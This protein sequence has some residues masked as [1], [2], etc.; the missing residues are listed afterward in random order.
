MSD[1][2]NSS[3]DQATDLVNCTILLNG[4]AI[5]GEYKVISLHGQKAFNRIADAKIVLSDG[6]PALQDFP[7]SSKDD[8]CKPGGKLEI[9]MGYHSQ[10]KTLFKGIIVSHSIR[11]AKNKQSFL[12][13]EARDQAYRLCLGRNNHC[14]ADQSDSDILEAV[15]K[16]AGYAGGDLDITAIAFKHRQMVQYN[17]SGWDFIVSRAEMNGMLVL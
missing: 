4:T 2:S 9:R 8:A 14:Y 10:A 3:R 15:A 12:I 17:V 16:A 13:S 6:D 11:S 5:S 7:I 1:N